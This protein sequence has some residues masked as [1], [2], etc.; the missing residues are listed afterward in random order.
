MSNGAVLGT[1][2]TRIS[3]KPTDYTA[4]IA[5]ARAHIEAN[6]GADLSL[7]ALADAAAL[8]RFHFSRVFRAMTGEGV[9]EAV[10]RVRMNRAA[11]T[12]VG[13]TDDIAS[14]AAQLG[15][16]NRQSFERAFRE[17]F[18]QTPLKMRREGRLPVPLLARDKGEIAMYPVRITEEPAITAAGLM[19]EG[20][21]TSIGATFQKLVDGL[22]TH[23]LWQGSGP[24]I[25]VHYTD[26]GETP[27]E[28]L[29]AHAAQ[30]LADGAKMPEGFDA[31]KVGGGAYA[32]LTYTG[33]YDGLA[34]AWQYLYG[35]WLPETGHS[36]RD[37]LPFERYV[38][39]SWDTPPEKRVTEICVP[40]MA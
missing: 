27:V 25:A 36:L 32:V 18:G 22:I 9:A 21:Y 26:P 20:A 4:R 23:R 6:L 35:R 15:Y 30:V 40:I 1:G 37:A 11:T 14:I 31:V 13:G 5:R 33:R 8:S 12:I 17:S 28:D 19:H 10:K 39:N 7:D 24:S 38:S 2:M 3:H 16:D 29:R 34:E